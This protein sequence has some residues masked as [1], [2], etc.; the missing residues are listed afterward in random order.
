M[1]KR[2]EKDSPLEKIHRLII[3]HEDKFAP[4]LVEQ[5]REMFERVKGGHREL[6]SI[7]E[8]ESFASAYTLVIGIMVEVMQGL[9]KVEGDE[10]VNFWENTGVKRVL[11]EFNNIDALVKCRK[12]KYAKTVELLDSIVTDGALNDTHLRLLTDKIRIYNRDGKLNIE[13]T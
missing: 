10:K 6:L 4:T 2:N 7:S 12:S 1:C 11:D 8:R 13:I 9:T 5:Q 3:Q